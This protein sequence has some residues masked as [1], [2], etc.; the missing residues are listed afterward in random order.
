MSNVK[1][2]V[3]LD[4]MTVKHFFKPIIVVFY[5][6]IAAMYGYIFENLA[7][8][9][10]YGMA[11]GTMVMPYSFIIAEK[12]SIDILYS[13]L[14]LGKKT[15]VFGRYLYVLIFNLIVLFGS[16]AC[17]VIG[18]FMESK[19]LPTFSFEVFL[20]IAI[21]VALFILIQSIQIPIIFKLGYTKAKLF[22]I[23]PVLL[24]LLL[25]VTV[26]SL[27]KHREDYEIVVKILNEMGNFLTK[28]KISIVLSIVVFIVL[29]LYI[30]YRISVKVYKKREF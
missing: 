22:S 14:P 6:G 2:F 13:T 1:A 16:I 12:C 8:G 18:I 17:T 25:G 21:V 23:V 19:K 9:I 15:V 28:N 30:S 11:I 10:G 7:G 5:M 26:S 29:C 4:F 27:Y 24:I 3:K 20:S